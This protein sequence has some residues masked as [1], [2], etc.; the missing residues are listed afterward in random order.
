MYPAAQLSWLYAQG[1][2]SGE[3]ADHINGVERSEI[4]HKGHTTNVMVTDLPKATI[5][6]KLHTRLH[7]AV[8]DVFTSGRKEPLDSRTEK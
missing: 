2:L 7:C 4:R 8:R 1:H 3:L 6:R 5:K